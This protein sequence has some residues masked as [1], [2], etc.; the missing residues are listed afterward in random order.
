MICRQ[1]LMQAGLPYGL[2]IGAQKICVAI[3]N[4]LNCVK[5]Q[6]ESSE[7][8]SASRMV[9]RFAIEFAGKP[10]DL[11]ASSNANRITKRLTDGYS[12]VPRCVFSA[13]DY[14][15]LQRKHSS[16]HRQAVWSW[17]LHN[18][19]KQVKGLSKFLHHEAQ[20]FLLPSTELT[21]EHIQKEAKGKSIAPT[22]ERE[23]LHGSKKTNIW[24]N[25]PSKHKYEHAWTI[26]IGL[27]R[28]HRQLIDSTTPFLIVTKHNG[29]SNDLN[30]FAFVGRIDKVQEHKGKDRIYFLVER[31]DSKRVAVL[32]LLKDFEIEEVNSASTRELM[33]DAM[34][35]RG[36]TFGR[37]YTK[38][39]ESFFGSDKTS[40]SDNMEEEGEEEKNSS[41]SSDEEVD[42]PPSSVTQ[43]PVTG[44]KQIKKSEYKMKN[45]PNA[46]V[47][48]LFVLVDRQQCPSKDSWVKA[49]A[50]SYT[51]WDLGGTHSL[52][53]NQALATEYE[54]VDTYKMAMC[55]VYAGLADDEAKFKHTGADIQG[56]INPYQKPQFFMMDL[57]DLLSMRGEWLMDRFAGTGTT[58]VSALKRGRNVIDVECDPLQVK[59]IEQRATA[60]KELPYEFQEVGTK[61]MASNPRFF[62]ASGEPQPPIGS[63][64]VWEIAD[65]VD[66]EP[67]NVEVEE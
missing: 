59:F 47:L 19:F 64:K 20:A 35:T 45:K 46:I 1:A 36:F 54:H 52:L 63:E 29:P 48:P 39:M 3:S 51:Y 18:L 11:S 55:W 44:T 27:P 62:D 16:T 37:A 67:D 4:G 42:M 15:K 22:H 61:T 8:P 32:L 38:V 24:D 56:I 28:E 25:V 41:S 5:L 30:K 31:D 58:T 60:L 53:V 6:C 57:I 66:F 13:L 21:R 33:I 17:H 65:L 26:C 7:H 50:E 9:M 14:L 12:K 40:S 23:T 49:N 43:T 10:Y 2:P 34:Q